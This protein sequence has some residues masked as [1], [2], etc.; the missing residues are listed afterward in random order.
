MTSLRSKLPCLLIHCLLDLRNLIDMAASCGLFLLQHILSKAL[1]Y[2]IYSLPYISIPPL[3]QLSL[4]TDN[5]H[6][7]GCPM[8]FSRGAF[9]SAVQLYS[10]SLNFPFFFHPSCYCLHSFIPDD[11]VFLKGVWFLFYR[12]FLLKL[13]P[14]R[15]LSPCNCFYVLPIVL[16]DSE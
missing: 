5:S 2:L 15:A 11:C 16:P 4:C 9:L 12:Y 14:L 6:F 1:L 10:Q 7:L 8:S 3:Q 13:L